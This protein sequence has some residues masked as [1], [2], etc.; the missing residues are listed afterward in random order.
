MPCH[1][2]SRIRSHHKG[3]P[4]EKHCFLALFFLLGAGLLTGCG[5]PQEPVVPVTQPVAAVPV[6]AAETIYT[7]G[8]A[9]TVNDQQPRAEALA[10]K[11]GKIIAVGTRADVE[12]NTQG[13]CYDGH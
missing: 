6:N 13:C 11:D 4:D 8:E 7:G 3:N 1:D 10:I 9:V 12:K 5:K 2:F